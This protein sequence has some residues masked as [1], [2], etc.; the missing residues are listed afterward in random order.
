VRIADTILRR[1]HLSEDALVEA[2]YTGDHPSHLDACALCAERALEVSRWLAHTR[3]LGIS[4]SDAAFPAERLAAQQAQILRRLEQLDRP[5]KLLS[6]PR[7]V[8]AAPSAG[9]LTT[10]DRRVSSRWIAAAAAAGLVLGVMA[11]RISLWQPA[12]QT[13]RVTAAPAPAAPA[14]LTPSPV[15]DP[16]RVDRSVDMLLDSEVTQP[17][18]HSLSAIDT[19]TPQVT[20]A[21]ASTRRR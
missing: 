16:V 15:A 6:F 1:G 3:D 5:S 11:G 12:P 17:Q 2:W 18:L 10:I 21:R 7:T 13:A 4:E 9:E 8:A 14:P 20:V 19:L